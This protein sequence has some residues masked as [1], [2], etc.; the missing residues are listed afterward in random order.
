M[1]NTPTKVLH[2][3]VNRNA[4][5]TENVLQVAIEL[6]I[7][8]LAVQEPWVV[9]SDNITYRSIN[10]PSFTQILPNYVPTIRPR[11]LFYI[12]RGLKASLAPNTPKDGDCIIIDLYTEFAIQII[13]VYNAKE[14][15]KPNSI[16]TIQRA[17]PSSLN[18]NTILL[19]DFNTHD[20]W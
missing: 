19:G 18:S 17:I 6:D 7:S 12:V 5:T 20:P 1:C 11:V 10:H 8:I 2:I 3:N 16:E 4:T 15:N 14:L 9:T 13:N